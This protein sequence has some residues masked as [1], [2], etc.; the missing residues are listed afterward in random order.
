MSE[1]VSDSTVDNLVGKSAPKFK[2]PATSGG[3]FKLADFKGSQVVI[4]FY[5]RDATP[6]CTTQSSDF[7]TLH[8]KFAKAN[9]Q[10]VGISQDTI[11][12]H[13]KFSKKLSLPFE[14]LSDESGDVCRL[15]GVLKLK[16]MYGKEFIGIERSTFLVDGA[17][18][19]IQ[20]WR[21]V[22][23]PGHVKEVLAVAQL[24]S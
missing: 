15:Y 8:K 2:L 12:S 24:S 6:G 20:Q 17:G 13:E 14:L 9:T 3:D 5:P 19:V 4:Y 10:V 18:K 11:K 22:K 21:K 1:S 7:A 23:V 16:K